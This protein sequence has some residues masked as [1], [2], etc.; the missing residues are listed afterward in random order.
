[1]IFMYLLN[2]HEGQG[3]A[4]AGQP[5]AAAVSD[6]YCLFFVE[7]ALPYYGNNLVYL[8][9][10]HTGKGRAGAGQPGAAAVSDSLLVCFVE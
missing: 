3:R 2:T 9:N 1:M 5:D 8:F 4:G 6:I 7:E 10:T